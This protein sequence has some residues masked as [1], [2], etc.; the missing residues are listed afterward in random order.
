[1]ADVRDEERH[2]IGRNDDGHQRRRQQRHQ[3]EAEGQQRLDQQ[4]PHV[5]SLL[6]SACGLADQAFAK[7]QATQLRFRAQNLRQHLH[8]PRAIDAAERRLSF[9]QQLAVAQQLVAV[10]D[11]D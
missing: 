11:L 1:M 8:L 7:P 3:A 10:F 6:F 4:A 5:V 2:R 9:R